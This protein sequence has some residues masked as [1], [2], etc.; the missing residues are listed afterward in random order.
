MLSILRTNLISISPSNCSVFP[1]EL[2][3][4]RLR[5]KKERKVYFRRACG[6]GLFSG[7]F[8]PTHCAC[9]RWEYIHAGKMTT[10]NFPLGW[11]QLRENVCVSAAAARFLIWTVLLILKASLILSKS[12][13]NCIVNMY[14]Q[15]FIAF[16][17]NL[18]DVKRLESFLSVKGSKNFNFHVHRTE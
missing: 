4:F 5:G 12:T 17:R 10:W 11:R 7:A 3:A 18:H 8:P 14:L 6:L 16:S 15:M 13:E 9:G 2:C 1:L